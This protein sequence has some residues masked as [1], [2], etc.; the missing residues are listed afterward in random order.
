MAVHGDL[1]VMGA[2]EFRSCLCDVLRTYRPGQVDIDLSG[3][4]FID[5]SGCRTLLWADMRVR[6]RGGTM[7]VVRPSSLVLRL[8]RLLEF[9]R[10]LSIRTS[11]DGDLTT[12]GLEVNPRPNRPRR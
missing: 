5:C 6:G 8:L 9:D 3:V 2:G 4:D 10:E 1:D 12:L 11:Q 7:A